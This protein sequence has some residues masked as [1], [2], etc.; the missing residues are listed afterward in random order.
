MASVA[1]VGLAIVFDDPPVSVYV[2]E[3]VCVNDF[4]M[5]ENSVAV[6]VCVVYSVDVLSGIESDELST[7]D[8]EKVSL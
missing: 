7:G 2:S 5:P 8:V 1:S 4:E 6:H 3:G